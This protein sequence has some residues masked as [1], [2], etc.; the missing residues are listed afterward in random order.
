M[1]LRS[2][3]IADFQSLAGRIGRGVVRLRPEWSA[4]MSFLPRMTRTQHMSSNLSASLHSTAAYPP[5][6]QFGNRGL[7]TSE[8]TDIRFCLPMLSEAFAVVHKQAAGE[9]ML[10]SLHFVDAAGATSHTVNVGDFESRLLFEQIL[11]EFVHREQSPQQAVVS[12][13]ACAP[14][15]CN[16]CRGALLCEW[17]KLKDAISFAALLRRHQLPRCHAFRMAQGVFTKCFKP[18]AIHP[19]LEEASSLHISVEIRVGNAA[20]E[21]V[22][23]GKILRIAAEGSSI[24]LR[25]PYFTLEFDKSKVAVVWL[26]NIPTKAGT[27]KSLELHDADG[28]T[29]VSFRGCRTESGTQEPSWYKALSSIRA[30]SIDTVLA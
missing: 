14:A 10:R 25:D 26:V 2:E 3:A 24:K 9:P 11:E 12:S 16:T 17:S 28:E 21:H 15:H 4:L 6:Q 18:V 5:Y 27:M 29:I 1:R 23:R 19:L 22:C 8:L 7:F 30:F 20:C 13:S